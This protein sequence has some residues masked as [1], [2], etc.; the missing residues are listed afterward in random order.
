MLIAGWV[1]MWKPIQTFLY[2]WWPV[3]RKAR[4]YAKMSRMRIT[5]KKA[6]RS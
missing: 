4:V 3:L 1:S 5:L 6:Q 2:D